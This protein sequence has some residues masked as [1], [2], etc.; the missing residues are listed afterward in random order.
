MNAPT[1]EIALAIAA[2]RGTEQVMRALG[3]Q[4]DNQEAFDV[5]IAAEIAAM[6]TFVAV[7]CRSEADFFAKAA[8]AL[9]Y[10][11]R[12]SGG[13]ALS[14]GASVCDGFGAL[15]LLTEAYLEQRKACIERRQPG[16]SYEEQPLAVG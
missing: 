6:E 2:H 10:G 15:A 14:E 13:G 9:E 5:A 7:P 1:V 4:D 12:Q 8:Y 16:A 3:D 11:V